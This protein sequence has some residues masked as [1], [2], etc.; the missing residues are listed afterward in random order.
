MND[1]EL[2]S[3]INYRRTYLN[4]ENGKEDLPAHSRALF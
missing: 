2:E 1:F 4:K 3:D